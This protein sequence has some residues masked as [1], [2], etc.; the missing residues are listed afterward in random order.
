M[1]SAVPRIRKVRNRRVER[2]LLST[3]LKG[4]LPNA[5][6]HLSHVPQRVRQTAPL[7]IHPLSEV[8]PLLREAPLVPKATKS[9]VPEHIICLSN[10]PKQATFSLKANGMNCGWPRFV[11][12]LEEK[13]RCRNGCLIGRMILRVWGSFTFPYGKQMDTLHAHQRGNTGLE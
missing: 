7:H 8:S 13:D 11:R 6:R 10:K 9:R 3:I 1:L 12:I 2:R 4:P 5:L